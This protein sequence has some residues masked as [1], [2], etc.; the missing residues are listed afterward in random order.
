MTSASVTV[1]AATYDEAKFAEMVVFGAELLAGDEGA[2]AT[3][4]NTLLSFADFSHVRRHGTPISAAEY[5]KL[6]WGPAPRRLL[7]VRRDLCAAG[8]IEIEDRVDP[9]GYRTTQVRATRPA[10]LSVF[11]DDEEA[12]I[13]S[14]AAL[15]RSMT[16]AQVSALSHEDPGWRLVEPGETIP[17]ESAYLQPDDEIPAGIE[18]EVH[19]RAGELAEQHA[20][21]AAG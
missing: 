14:V 9:L 1:M 16:A 4:L 10:D 18:F 21:R 12:T 3:K 13:R 17:Y 19:D 15:L 8:A 11:T 2:G 5:Q 7:P 6:N 20:H